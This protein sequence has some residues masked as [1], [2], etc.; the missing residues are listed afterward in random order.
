MQVFKFH[1]GVALLGL[2]NLCHVILIDIFAVYQQRILLDA[3]DLKA[4]FLIQAH[5][6]FIVMARMPMT[7]IR[8][9][10]VEM[11]KCQG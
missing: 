1:F 5:P 7:G 11:G 8:L 10:Q 6:V 4:I 2:E 9:F 3:F